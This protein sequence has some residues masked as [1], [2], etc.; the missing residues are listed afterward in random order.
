MKLLSR[1]FGSPQ[2][3]PRRQ[4]AIRSS[5]SAGRLGLSSIPEHAKTLIPEHQVLSGVLDRMRAAARWT[6]RETPHGTS[7]DRIIRAGLIAEDAPAPIWKSEP[8]PSAGMAADLWRS[9]ARNPRRCDW[10][11]QHTLRAMLDIAIGHLVA[12]GECFFRI[13]PGDPLR[14]ELI[15]PGRVPITQLSQNRSEIMGVVHNN[16]GRIVAYQVGDPA[17]NAFMP[18]QNFSYSE[19]PAASM[20]HWWLPIRCSA[21]RGVP[22]LYSV[23]SPISSLKEFNAAAVRHAAFAAKRIGK[24]SNSEDAGPYKGDDDLDGESSDKS[25]EEVTVEERDG[26]DVWNLPYGV[27]LSAHDSRF[28]DAAI[29]AFA[30]SIKS[31]MSAA[32]GLNYAE[33]SG[34]LAG[35]NFSAGR[36]GAMA[37]E[38][39]IS[40]MASSLSERVLVPT[41]RKFIARLMISGAIPAL[42]TPEFDRL[43][44]PDSWTRP[45]PPPVDPQKQAQADQINLEIGI[46]S[47]R[48][49]IERR[50]DNFDRI[51]KDRQAEIQPEPEA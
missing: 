39:T 36:L 23:V 13:R 7:I 40:R 31:D 11:G 28:P 4:S 24:L 19:I 45:V 42:D 35:V 44:M 37:Q 47:R 30:R 2:K 51:E 25:K 10:H 33:L 1:W 46:T 18:Y 49:I 29:E 5:P 9:W 48:S 8:P 26:M 38:K 12:D 32:T 50:G 20:L 22:L 14:L 41:F 15:D 16:Q 21:Y 43:S 34:D 3:P 17:I 6:Q 27:D